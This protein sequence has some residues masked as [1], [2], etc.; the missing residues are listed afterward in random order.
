[1]EF[2]GWI[3]IMTNY[4]RTT[5]YIGVTSDLRSRIYNHQNKIYPDS[6]TARYN[7]IYCVYYECFISI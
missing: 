5:L 6:F 3:Y 7:L 4:E 2:G 1:M